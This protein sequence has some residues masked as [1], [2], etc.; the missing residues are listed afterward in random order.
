MGSQDAFSLGACNQ[1]RRRVRVD[2]A[3]LGHALRL[4][5]AGDHGDVV[6]VGGSAVFSPC[7]KLGLFQGPSSDVDSV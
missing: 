1:T 2:V 5:I 6:G 4:F 7:S 3:G